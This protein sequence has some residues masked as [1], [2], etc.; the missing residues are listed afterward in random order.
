VHAQGFQQGAFPAQQLVDFR[1]DQSVH[2]IK[3]YP[4]RD[5]GKGAS[6]PARC[7]QSVLA[8]V[9]ESRDGDGR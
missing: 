8:F 2:R 5:M 1:S 7:V 4:L 9:Q 3:S 6:D